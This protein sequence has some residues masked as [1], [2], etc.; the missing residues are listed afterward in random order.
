MMMQTWDSEGAREPD[1][2]ISWFL[3]AIRDGDAGAAPTRKALEEDTR[4]VVMAGR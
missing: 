2:M 4:S 1:D 3:K